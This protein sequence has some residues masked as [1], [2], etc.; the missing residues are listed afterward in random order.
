M[1]DRLVL[2]HKTAARVWY[3]S[4]WYSYGPAVFVVSFIWVLFLLQWLFNYELFYEIMIEN[5]AELAFA[6][7]LDIFVDAMLNVFRYAND[8]TPISLIAISFFQASILT[9]WWR[10]RQITRAS[11]L[12]MGALGVGI[13]GSGCVACGSSLLPLLLDIVGA[14]LSV[15]L[16]QA[17]GDILLVLAVVLSYRATLKLALR[18]SAA[19]A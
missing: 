3:H 5:R 18:A 13:L 15:T 7:R 12:R 1:I 16:V 19:L 4:V 6:E 2:E 17:I 11:R 8:L 10:L 9:I 14:T